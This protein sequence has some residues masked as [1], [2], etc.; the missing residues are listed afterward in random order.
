VE[1]DDLRV[2]DWRVI[3]RGVAA[4]LD[5]HPR[6]VDPVDHLQVAGGLLDEA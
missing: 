3:A 2:V 1:V 4:W 5:E 6:M